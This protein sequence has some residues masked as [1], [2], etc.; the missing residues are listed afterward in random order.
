MSSCEISA[1][2]PAS[3]KGGRFGRSKAGAVYKGKTFAEHIISTLRGAGIND[4]IV[5]D[6]YDTPDMLGTIRRALKNRDD[7]SVKGWLIWPVDHPFVRQQTI[8]RLREAFA[9]DPDAIIRPIYNGLHGHPIIIPLSLNLDE[10]DGG[11]GLAGVI[12]N[13]SCRV[14]DIA[15]E[16]EG[17]LRNINYWEDLED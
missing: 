5:A 15:V 2:I 16:D 4:I 13:Q 11:E 8:S 1:I 17:I 9:G 12:R 7:D 14:A 6:G 10:D 3:G